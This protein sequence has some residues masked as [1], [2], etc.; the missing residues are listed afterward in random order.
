LAFYLFL[1]FF[2]DSYNQGLNL[3]V[4]L[5]KR[6]KL[7]QVKENLDF[8]IN[9]D[10]DVSA[11]RIRVLQTNLEVLLIFFYFLYLL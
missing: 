2:L 8:I 3:F 9:E 5:F 11:E 10:D 7:K 1:L 4:Y 6:K